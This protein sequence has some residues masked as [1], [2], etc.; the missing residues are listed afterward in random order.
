[1]VLAWLALFDSLIAIAL[2]I[3]GMCAAHFGYSTPFFGFI[4]FVGGLFFAVL[5]LF[6]AIIALLVML[7]SPR[8]RSALPRAVIGG[9][10]G[11]IVLAPVFVVVITHR[12]YPAIND[13][14][15]DTKNPPEFVHA[16]ELPANR[17]RSMKYDAATYAPV[18]EN[19]AVY[20][21]LGPLKLDL[22]PDDAYKKVEIIAGEVTDWQ[23]TSSDPAKRTI[24]GIATSPLFHFKD[25]FVIEVRPAEGGGSSL[26]EMRSK[27]RDG[28]GDLG[29]NYNR[30][31]SFF[32]LLR[33]AHGKPP[34]N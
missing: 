15:T 14:T 28:K 6:F 2:A 23:I 27:S 21:N 5:A 26:I 3:A 13:I 30:I 16:Q 25:D 11:L 22:A 17:G 20:R 1:M 8:R 12:Q 18:Q 33:G 9:A 34:M 31:E 4:L 24:E 29:V 10:F 7:F 32:H 19:A